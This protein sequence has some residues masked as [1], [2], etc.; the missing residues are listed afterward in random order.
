MTKNELAKFFDGKKKETEDDLKSKV[1][2]Y[3]SASRGSNFKA[4]FMKKNENK[5][6]DVE[7]Y[8]YESDLEKYR[9]P[10]TKEDTEEAAYAYK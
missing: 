2:K 10:V 5:N 3:S 8:S 4:K 6:G 9:D 1:S 7:E